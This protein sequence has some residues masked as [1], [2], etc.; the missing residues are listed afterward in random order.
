M[1]T[2]KV[3][4]ADDNLALDQ[5]KKVSWTDKINRRVAGYLRAF[6]V[7]IIYI[8]IV[9]IFQGVLNHLSRIPQVATSGYYLTSLKVISALSL[10]SPAVVAL[11]IAITYSKNRLI[12]AASVLLGFPIIFLSSSIMFN[13]AD[14]HTLLFIFNDKWQIPTKFMPLTRELSEFSVIKPSIFMGFILGVLIAKISNIF[15]LKQINKANEIL[16]TFLI[17][18]I[19]SVGL[20]IANS[21]LTQLLGF[22]LSKIP[23]GKGE[24]SIF[25]VLFQPFAWLFAYSDVAQ[26]MYQSYGI[27]TVNS[28][29]YA[30][31][32]NVFVLPAVLIVFMFSTP[33]KSF[34]F[35]LPV[36][37]FA[38]L[39]SLG[40]GQSQAALLIVF[41]FSPALFLAM[42]FVTPVLTILI[43]TL[44][45]IGLADVKSNLVDV[46]YQ[47]KDLIPTKWAAAPVKNGW[48]IYVAGAVVFFFTFLAYILTVKLGKRTHWG[49]GFA[50]H[51]VWRIENT[52]K[53]I[54]YFLSGKYREEKLVH[55]R[56]KHLNIYPDE[57]NRVEYIDEVTKTIEIQKSRYEDSGLDNTRILS[58]G[59]HFHTIET[60]GP[61]QLAPTHTFEQQ[62]PMQTTGFVPVPPKYQTYH[63]VTGEAP[64]LIQPSQPTIQEV[65]A[66]IER[67]TLAPMQAGEQPVQGSKTIYVTAPTPEQTVIQAT[68]TQIY[69]TVPKPGEATTTTQVQFSQ[70]QAQYADDSSR[71]YTFDPSKQQMNEFLTESKNLQEETQT[72]R[73]SFS[74]P[75]VAPSPEGRGSFVINQNKQDFDDF[76]TEIKN[77]K[78]QE[79]FEIEN[80]PEEFDFQEKTVTLNR[81]P[82]Q[83]ETTTEIEVEQPTP[84]QFKDVT[85]TPAAKPKSYSF[86]KKIK[87]FVILSPL[88]GEIRAIRENSIDIYSSSGKLI[89]PNDAVVEFITKEKDVFILDMYGVKVEFKM[90]ANFNL[91]HKQ[92]LHNRTFVTAGKTLYKGD[93]FID[94]N[95]K[96]YS[97][98]GEEMIIT[99]T[100]LPGKHRLTPV[101][102]RS[103]KIDKWTGLFEVNLKSAVDARQRTAE[104]IN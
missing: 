90:N 4:L 49:K 45:N 54:N 101:R 89:M 5:K 48:S 63:M 87:D 42:G 8:L 85:L 74:T 56:N 1:D 47:L 15:A 68:P 44:Q 91:P 58:Q 16:Y 103:R 9:G 23:T 34:G 50:T 55:I 33:R 11:S 57:D 6:L 79:L 82:L 92:S 37:F 86:S 7:P 3:T 53:Q 88:L 32:L 46:S 99:I 59:R 94:G 100:V 83:Y 75:T 98:I 41:I 84:L 19:L 43:I 62:M 77:T 35:I 81:K 97:E 29:P 36:Y 39:S 17:I 70:P 60:A 18:A 64:R 72:I 66:P 51:K 30:L 78:E 38:F 67:V 20:G 95:K 71:T 31:M 93:F 80:E 12:A 28:E 65:R 52:D 27:T 10:L 13:W 25:G 21:L 104:E 22:G 73:P 14:Q 102:Q 96:F 61:Q 24:A 2:Q 69:Y 76:M 26:S 40:L